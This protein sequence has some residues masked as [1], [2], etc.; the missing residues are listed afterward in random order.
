MKGKGILSAF[1]LVIFGIFVL[2]MPQGAVAKK[3]LKIGAVYIL[4]GAFATYGQFARNGINLAVDEI[5]A[6][7]GILGR[8]VE[9]TFEDSKAKPA[10]AIRAFRKLVYEEKVDFL[11]G[12][13]SSGVALGVV[14]TLPE[15]K[16]I[17]IITH[18]A[19]PDVTGK[20]CNKYAFRISVNL[21]QNV[22][23]GARIAAKTGAKRWTTIGP[24]YAFG[25]QSWEYFQK[26]LKK[27]VP[28][29]VFMEKVAFPKL[30]TEDY[31]TYITSI[32]DANPEGVFI[33]LWGGDLVNF[34]RQ[35]NAYGFFKKG[36]K[37]LMS[38]GAATEVL[39]ALK[40]KMPEG[41]WVG[42]RYWFLANPSPTNK[43]FVEAYKKRYNAY[44][45]YN[46]QNAYTAIYA[47]KAAIEKAK[48]TKTEAVIKALEGLRIEAPVGKIYIRPQ[49]HQAILN[50]TWGKTAADPNYPIRILKPMVTFSGEEVTPSPEETGC[51]MK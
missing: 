15:L 21:N 17:L 5:N 50:V 30:A 41:V 34:V 11:V 25:H 31:S 13:D 51:K 45:S 40:D 39:Y 29:A 28:D 20:K 2:G 43:R 16:R 48:S 10:V 49:D 8:K 36:Y 3:P 4:S 27:L 22:G 32:M 1:I 26:Y 42:T 23:A 12:L 9:V 35:A 46:A 44:P 33:S 14:P 7:G 19:T 6:K 18:A 47:L 38:L 37:V 24:D